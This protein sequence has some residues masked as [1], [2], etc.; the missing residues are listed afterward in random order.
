MPGPDAPTPELIRTLAEVGPWQ[1]R[2]V[3]LW[4]VQ[5][6]V[7]DLAD[8]KPVSRRRY[9]KL[10]L[11]VARGVRPAASLLAPYAGTMERLRRGDVKLPRAGRYFN[12]SVQNWDREHPDALRETP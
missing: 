6:L 3:A 7:H 10:C 5:A 1:G 9:E 11:E 4:C 12:A 8:D 2:S